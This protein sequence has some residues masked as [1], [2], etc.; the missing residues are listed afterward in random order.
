MSQIVYE[1]TVAQDLDTPRTNRLLD[2][3]VHMAARLQARLELA[4]ARKVV[5]ALDARQVADAGIDTSEILPPSP[6][7]ALEVGL[8]TRLMS[9]R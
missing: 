9:M 1:T 7:F 8:M 3:A 2:R 4:H 6:T 5:R